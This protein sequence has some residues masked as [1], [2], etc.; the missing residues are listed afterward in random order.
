MSLCVLDGDIVGFKAAAAC[1]KRFI[2]AKHIVSGKSQRF[3]HRTAFRD[4]LK[5]KEGKWQEEDFEIIDDREVDPIEN[6][7]HTVKTMVERIHKG[8]GCS[9]LKLVVQ[10]DGN[11]RDELPLPTKYKGSRADT[12]RPLHLAEVRNYI[13]RKYKAEL[14]HGREGDDVLAEYAFEGYKTKKKIVQATT[15]KDAKQCVGYL[16]N[17]DKMEA[18]VFVNGL[19]KLFL[20]AKNEVDGLGRKWLYLQ[21]L[22]GD[23][24]DSYKPTELCKVRYG[25]KS[26]L[27]DLID[28]QSD[29]ECWQ[30]IND[31]YLEWYPE[32]VKY[33]AWNGEE[34]TKDYIEIMDMYTACAHMRRSA[35][36]HLDVRKVLTDMG[37]I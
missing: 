37:I 10:G 12:I 15:D 4:W 32:P 14:A 28:L 34:V 33:T 24:T 18:P 9:E 5:S 29:K 35:T 8:S 30:K 22:I 11:F 17:W 31:K 16:Y 23:P 3:D 7:L 20:N 26:A 36:D 25:E 19:G 21:M 1:E 2:F 6:C 13:I 27:K